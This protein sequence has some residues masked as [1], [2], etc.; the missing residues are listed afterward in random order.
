V[1]Y[2]PLHD[3]LKRHGYVIYAGQGPL[4][5]EIFRVCCLGMLEPEVLR[6]FGDR[7]GAAIESQ[8]AVPA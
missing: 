6:A 2:A 7:L 3:E 1:R 8:Q 5:K 4:A